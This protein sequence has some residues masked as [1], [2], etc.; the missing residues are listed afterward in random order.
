M[1]LFK[2]ISFS[3]IS[4]LICFSVVILTMTV[5]SYDIN[6]NLTFLEPHFSSLRKSFNT[7]EEKFDEKLFAEN[8][9]YFFQEINKWNRDQIILEFYF[10]DNIINVLYYNQTE[11]ISEYKYIYNFV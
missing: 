9:S 2:K 3:I 10:K 1:S 6:K 8:Y 7:Y 4:L 11:L 5:T